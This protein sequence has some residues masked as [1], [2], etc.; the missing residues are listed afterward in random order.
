[1]GGAAADP[2]FLKAV[3]AAEVGED[4]DP[5]STAAGNIFAV[6]VDGVTPP[7]VKPIDSVR[8]Q[9]LAAWTAEQDTI[10]LKAKAVALAASINSGRKLEDVA[11]EVGA[12]IEKSPALT[13]LTRDPAFPPALLRA[14]YGATPGAAAFAPAADGSYVIARVTGVVHPIPVPSDPT[15]QGGVRQ[16]SGE[17]SQDFALLL[18]KAIQARDGA[19]VNQKLIDATVGGSNSGS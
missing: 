16:L 4:G 9:A 17:I 6:K 2:D 5:V 10:Q 1:M 18:A 7:K 14:I 15:Y 3:F 11:K 19:R 12:T 8:V 13:R